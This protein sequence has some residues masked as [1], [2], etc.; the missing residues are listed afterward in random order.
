MFKKLF[1]K[2]STSKKDEK[3]EPEILIGMIAVMDCD[4]PCAE[5]MFKLYDSL[6]NNQ[7]IIENIEEKENNILFEVNG[8]LGFI[9]LMPAP[10]PWGDLEGPCLTAWHWENAEEIMKSHKYH[11]LISLMPKNEEVTNIERALIITRIIAS[12]LEATDS[13]GV[14]WAP[15]TIINSK[16]QFITTAKDASV[17]ELPI[18]LWIEFR[19]EKNEN[20]SFNII[21][22]GMNS[23]GH[24]ELEIVNSKREIT[25]L[26]GFVYNICNYLLENG[27]VIKDGDTVGMDA[28]QKINAYYKKSVWSREN[29]VIQIQY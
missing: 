21:T 3:Q 14:L 10:I 29:E 2:K 15:G 12:V 16:E 22:T 27:P 18:N 25:E 28:D 19:I 6:S 13:V 5:N 1:S 26:L 20:N 23:L 8:E 9:S 4:M 17:E 24:K 11:Y 7:N